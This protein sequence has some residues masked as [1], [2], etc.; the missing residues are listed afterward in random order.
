MLHLQ[1]FRR[2]SLMYF[3]LLLELYGKTEPVDLEAMQRVFDEICRKPNVEIQGSH[4]AT[5]VS[6]Y[7]CTAKD[8]DRAIGIFESIATHPSTA[9]SKTSLP[10]AIVYEALF[11]VLSFHHRQDLIPSY[12]RRLED[13]HIRPTAYVLNAVIRGYAAAGDI[14]SAR[15]IFERMEDPAIGK[16]APFNRPSRSPKG[17]VEVDADGT[18]HIVYREVWIS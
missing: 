7:G 15:A 11:N 2:F 17:E 4:W 6:V 9:R 3:Q 13:T 10:D 18:T 14:E 16:A 12:I 8:L 1:S 5:L